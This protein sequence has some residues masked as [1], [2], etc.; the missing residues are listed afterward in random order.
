MEE[1][2]DEGFQSCMS[3]FAKE[4][5]FTAEVKFEGENCAKVFIRK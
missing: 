3:A 4:F 5:G 1:K 2:M